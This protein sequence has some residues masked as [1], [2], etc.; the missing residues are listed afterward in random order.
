MPATIFNQQALHALQQRIKKL[1]GDAE[2]QWGTMT[3]AQMCWHCRQ[4]LEFVI[5]PTEVQV[6]KTMFRFQPVKWLAIFVIKWP[7]GARTAPSM[8]AQK[9]NPALGSL[10]EEK[11]TLL[12]ALDK[13]LQL[14]FI[15]AVHPLFGE[16][17]KQYW[18][19]LIWKHLDHHLRQFNC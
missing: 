9:S 5:A 1:S 3:A 12:Q 17:G 10:A 15:R 16:L 4:Q 13:V 2:R 19:R 6:L 8:D 14:P 18:G 7:E 11:A